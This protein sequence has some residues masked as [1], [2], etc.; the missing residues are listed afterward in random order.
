[1]IMARLKLVLAA[2]LFVA[3]I[4]WLVYL[5]PASAWV[6]PF[7][8]ERPIVLS[9]PQFLVS[10]LD[11]IAEIEKKNVNPPE[12]SVRDV[13][14]PNDEQTK[15]LIGTKIRVTN[16]SS[17]DGWTQPGEYIV[18]LMAGSKGEYQIV[19]IPP[20]PGYHLGKAQIYPSTPETRGQ[21]QHIPKAEPLPAPK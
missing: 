16:L 7:Q 18:P 19:P 6:Y 12:I 17:C 2:V 8:P 4:G 5:V 10:N 14:W 9:R 20:S 3:W 21:L 1:M 15:K 11:V 13:P